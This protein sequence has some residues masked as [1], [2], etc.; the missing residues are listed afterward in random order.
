M[1]T[2]KKNNSKFS[3]FKFYVECFITYG[4]HEQNL[5]EWNQTADVEFILLS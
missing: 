5:N 3:G 4:L 1:R 2:T